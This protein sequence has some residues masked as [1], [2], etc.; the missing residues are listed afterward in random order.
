[1]LTI[2]PAEKSKSEHSE[3]GAPPDIIS[4]IEQSVIVQETSLWNEPPSLETV[5]NPLYSQE[6]SQE[7][8]SR[9][10]SSL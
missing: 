4:F 8:S 6:Y 5:V 7:P 10:A 3:N 2:Y 1:M 9:V